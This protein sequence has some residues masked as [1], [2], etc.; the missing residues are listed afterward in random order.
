[1]KDEGEDTLKPVWDASMTL[2][3]VKVSVT[4]PLPANAEQLRRRLAVMGAAWCFVASSHPEVAVLRGVEM[5]LC[6]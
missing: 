6:Y 4:I 2:K 5:H 1:M 3:A